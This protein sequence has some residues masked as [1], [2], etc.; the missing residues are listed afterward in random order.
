MSKADEV[1]REIEKEASRNEKPTLG[2]HG[3]KHPVMFLPIIGPVKGA[4]LEKVIKESKPRKVL[5]VGTLV[6]YSVILMAKNMK[7][8]KIV[9]L[10]IDE[11]AANIAKE[12]LEKSG[13]SEKVDIIVGD[14]KEIIKNLKDSFDLI[15]IDA[16]KNEYY[17][18]LKLVE[19]NIHKDTVVFADNAKV[20]AD[21]MKDYLNYVRNSGRYRSEF[22]DCGSDGVEVS[23]F[24]G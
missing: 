14:A 8:G 19:K 24:L 15:F 13:L 2:L 6:G 9:S 22:H 20:L 17:T 10:E 23:V 11:K 18:Y 12:N 1:L 21:E 5:E 4:L 7:D 3:R 16:A